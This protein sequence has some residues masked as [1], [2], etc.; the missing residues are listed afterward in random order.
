MEIDSVFAAIDDLGHEEM[1]QPRGQRALGGAGKAA[2]EVTPVGEIAVLVDETEDVDDG[3]RQHPAGEP[4]G[5]ERVEQLMDD[6]EAVE[7]VPVDGG[8]EPDRRSRLL[9]V[10]HDDGQRQPVAGGEPRN[11]EIESQPLAG[12]DLVAA[13]LEDVSHSS[14]VSSGAPAVSRE[15]R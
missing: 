8:V 1:C 11:V 13:D 5:V 2:V 9:A 3:H 14:C 4:A 7:L 6:F 15:T 10:E 12:W